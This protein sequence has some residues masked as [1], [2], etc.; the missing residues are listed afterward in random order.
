M[1]YPTTTITYPGGPYKLPPGNLFVLQIDLAVGQTATLVMRQQ[2]PDPTHLPQDLSIRCH[3][4]HKP[5]GGSVIEN[6]PNAA[7]WHLSG[8]Q[9]DAVV[10]YDVST[11]E[12][13]EWNAIKIGLMPGRY[14]LNVLNLVNESN[15]FSLDIAF[16]G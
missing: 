11:L 15:T 9:S 10:L 13:P 4:S 3:I 7:S 12:E 2:A 16:G 6:P 14:W 8:L 1:L 5:G